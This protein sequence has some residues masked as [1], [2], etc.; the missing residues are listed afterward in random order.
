MW[1]FFSFKT[2]HL[3][4]V[5]LLPSDPDPRSLSAHPA[6]Y[7]VAVPPPAPADDQAPECIFVAVSWKNALLGFFMIR[8]HSLLLLFP[9]CG[10]RQEGVC[11]L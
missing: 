10:H 5:S 3:L 11:G 8:M 7:A 6:S 2:V 9:A 4:A 1:V